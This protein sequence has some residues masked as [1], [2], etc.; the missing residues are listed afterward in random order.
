M[1]TKQRPYE[2]GRLITSTIAGR[3]ADAF[4]EQGLSQA[5]EKRF[6]QPAWAGT[7]YSLPPRAAARDLTTATASN[8]GDLVAESIAA[9]AQSVRPVTVLERA[10]MQVIETSGDFFH[11]PRWT[12]ASAG[13]VA[14]NG[15]VGSLGTAVTTVDLAP[16]IAG[17]RLAFSRRLSLLADGIEQQ[18]LAE[19]S[20]AV[21]SLIESA[22]IAG[23]GVSSQPLGL[24]NLPGKKSKTF[25]GATPTLA[26]LSDMV[27]LVTDADADADISRLAFVLHPSD[28]RDLLIAEKVAS[29]GELI[30]QWHEGRYRIFGVPVF[31]T[32]NC[33]EGKVLL[34][35][36]SAVNL[37]FFGPPQA[38]VDRYSGGKAT[39]GQTEVVVLNMTDVVV[40]NESAICVG[41]A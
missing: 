23:S 22:V 14:E 15:S 26:E 16:K 25:A 36:F 24:L 27:E 29:T 12:A 19:V 21:S 31:I 8:G 13:W 37:V 17:A 33:T 35:D 10:G 18:V 39:T 2:F 38:I 9:V 3:E 40:T 20:R 11:L 7:G 41:S 34:G 28:L 5:I 30:V 4:Y 32:T 6:G 1:D